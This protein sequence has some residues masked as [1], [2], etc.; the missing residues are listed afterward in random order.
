MKT[1]IKNIL[2]VEDSA[3]D[4]T[5]IKAGLREAHFGNEIV[6]AEDGEEALDFLYKRGKFA[7]YVGDKPI[8]ILLDIKL[9][10]MNGIEVLKVIREDAHFN[11]VPVIMLTSSR[12]SHDLQEC[13][14]NGANSFV[15][16]PV[17]INEF[18]LVV[19]EVGQYWVVVN[20]LPI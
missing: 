4:V 3:N 2:L 20:E 1:L 10:L 14:N 18:M 5:L 7:S 11:D 8:F 6:V 13:Y 16:K 15:V 19:K 17:N 12:D 9:P